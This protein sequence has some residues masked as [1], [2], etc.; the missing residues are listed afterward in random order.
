MLGDIYLKKINKKINNL[1]ID[2]KKFNFKIYEL[3]NK[4][5]LLSEYYNIVGGGE[6]LS[7]KI[8]EL[9][10]KIDEIK[11]QNIKLKEENNKLLE[12]NQ[13]M[14]EENNK[15]KREKEE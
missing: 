12:E 13:K 8:R 10:D 15:L 11:E 5:K 6:K 4:I 9:V 2:D 7:E 1:H 3:Q 14:K